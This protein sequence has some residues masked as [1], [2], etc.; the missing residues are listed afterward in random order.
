MRNH[1]ALVLFTTAGILFVAV[2]IV[3]FNN[4]D[5]SLILGQLTVSNALVNVGLAIAF[6]V[7]FGMTMRVSFRQQY[8]LHLAPSDVITLPIM[9]HLFTYIIPIK[10][11]LLFQVFYIRHK[12]KL[13][14]SKSFSLGITTFMVSVFLTVVIGLGLSLQLQL[15]TDILPSVFGIIGFGLVTLPIILWLLPKQSAHFEGTIYKLLRFLIDLRNELLSQI[16]NLRLVTGLLLTGLISILIQS[17]WFWQ[18]AT[19]LGIEADLNLVI[20]VVL[21]LRIILLVRL[22]PGNL[23]IQELMI[24]GVFLMAGF[25]IEEGLAVAL[26]TRLV[27]VF[28]AATIGLI[29]LYSNLQYYE[30]RKL[31]ALT[32]T[33]AKTTS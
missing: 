14:L 4:M 26:L 28:L 25:S 5:L 21:I 27:S 22:L 2:A 11:G 7:S 17:L 16:K 8:K 29:G 10:G 31:S 6:F 19:V 13:E 12:Y 9:M 3:T 15:N 23:G 32:K 30:S 33:V 20:L 18:S 24:G 1:R